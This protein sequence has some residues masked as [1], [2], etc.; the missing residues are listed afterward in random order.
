MDTLSERFLNN[1]IEG[2]VKI[3]DDSMIGCLEWVDDVLTMTQDVDKAK[4]TLTRVD[5]FAK[6][7][8][9]QWGHDKCKMMQVGKKNKV[10]EEWQLGDQLIGD[11]TS[12][13]Y[14]GEEITSDGKN[15]KNH[16]IQ[17]K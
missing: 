7:N 15:E 3:S 6:A 11:T 4:E 12:Y 13:K 1:E 14:L 16:S 17:R 10:P 9:L 8:K 2:A 5:D